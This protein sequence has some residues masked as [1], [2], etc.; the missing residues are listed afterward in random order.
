M[1]LVV[2]KKDEL[3]YGPVLITEGRHKGRVGYYD[4]EDEDSPHLGSPRCYGPPHRF[5]PRDAGSLQPI[6]D[7]CLAGRAAGSNAV[8]L[9][10]RTKLVKEDKKWPG[11]GMF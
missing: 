10:R 11:T 5:P 9:R 4:N 7:H 8:G 1:R 2:E 6:H 3:I